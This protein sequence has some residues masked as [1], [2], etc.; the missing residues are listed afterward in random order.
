MILTYAY[1]C[2]TG[3]TCKKYVQNELQSE[4]FIDSIIELDFNTNVLWATY[5]ISKHPN[6]S[7][8]DYDNNFA[9][10]IKSYC[11]K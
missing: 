6:L 11:S 10:Y 1:Q 5:D 9:A 2:S 3:K 7:E 8:K 4:L